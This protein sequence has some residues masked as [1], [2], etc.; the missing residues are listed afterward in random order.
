MDDFGGG[1]SVTTLW[2]CLIIMTQWVQD[3]GAT[4][5]DAKRG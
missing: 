5:M 3:E 1:I 4:S 2:A